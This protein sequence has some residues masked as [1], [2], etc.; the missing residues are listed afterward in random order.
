MLGV[1][2]GVFRVVFGQFPGRSFGEKLQILT[3]NPLKQISK[4]QTWKKQETLTGQLSV[5]VA[6]HTGKTQQH[7]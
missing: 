3:S 7:V 1:I 6:K 2:G 4:E 5:V